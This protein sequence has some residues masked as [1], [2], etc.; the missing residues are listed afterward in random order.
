MRSIRAPSRYG[1]A[2][3]VAFAF[4]VAKSINED[5]PRTYNE[6]VTSKDKDKWL[7]AMKEEIQ[8]TFGTRILNKVFI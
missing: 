4:S 5:E 7:S 1:Y 3:I 8:V 6:A 2:E